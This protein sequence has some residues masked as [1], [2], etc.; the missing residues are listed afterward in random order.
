MG[1]QQ[2]SSNQHPAALQ[3]PPHS[4]HQPAR[5]SPNSS[6]PVPSLRPPQ[7]CCWA[8]AMHAV[9]LTP[10]TTMA[11]HAAAV[12]C[13]DPLLTRATTNT[14]M[15]CCV[16]CVCRARGRGRHARDEGD[17]DEELL[18]DEEGLG[19]AGV[20]R[21]TVQPSILTGGTLR[22]YQMQGL[23]WLIH[24]YDNG[25]NGI[26]ADEM[27][28]GGG[29][30]TRGGGQADDVVRGR[31]GEG[32]KGGEGGGSRGWGTSHSTTACFKQ[33]PTTATTTLLHA[34]LSPM[35][36]NSLELLPASCMSNLLP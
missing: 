17:E 10:H 5:R 33:S 13:P 23:N 21:L 7:C 16:C 12:G 1:A 30:R 20:H 3:A 36:P 27:V 18:K 22:E 14:R 2:Q 28:R 31:C 29:G 34:L 4:S 35:W 26:L 25:I 15:A 24:L 9:R 11:S 32:P 6:L 19:G 8:L